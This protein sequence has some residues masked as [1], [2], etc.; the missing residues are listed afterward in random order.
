MGKG[1]GMTAPALLIRG[2][3]MHHR[4]RPVLN[5][6]V[7]PVFYVRLNLSQLHTI[8]AAW[9]GID[10]WRPLSLRTQDYG[11]RDGSSLEMWM[12]QVLAENNIEADGDIWRTAR[13]HVARH[14][15]GHHRGSPSVRCATTRSPGDRWIAGDS[16]PWPLGAPYGSST[17]REH[18]GS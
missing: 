10:C 6:F 4:L 5:R 1:I 12:R 9:F 13:R 8:R 14:T 7:Y 3:V 15:H 18:S 11:P 2:Q 17:A 16:T